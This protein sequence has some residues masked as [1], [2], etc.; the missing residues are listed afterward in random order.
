MPDDQPPSTVVHA[1]SAQ[2]PAR[3]RRFSEIL[4]EIASD[5]G[6]ERVS[7]GDLLRAMGDR[8]FGA[9]M[10]VFA[11]PNVLPT[12]PGTSAI[13]GLPLVFLAAQLMLGQKPWLPE[14]V[15]RR[16]IS[17]TDFAAL[18]ERATPWL[19]RAERLLKPRLY[20]C[21]RAPAEYLIG[22]ICLVLAV[23][24]VLPIPLGNIPP[25]FAVCLF[26][27]A[28]IERDG[29]WAIAGWVIAIASLV[30]V[31]GVMFALAKGAIF[32]F[33]NVFN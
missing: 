28:I 30:I 33:T 5:P 19:A 23:I 10:L 1:P 15:A 24:L 14:V 8:A 13:L 21:V 9:L 26:S 20:S 27:F 11:L 7:V 12:P 25:A 22:G 32:V 2:D 16:S 6:R 29:L 17:R 4:I 3:G 31:G 18:T